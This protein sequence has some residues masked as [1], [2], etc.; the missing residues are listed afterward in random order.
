MFEANKATF[1]FLREYKLVSIIMIIALSL[2]FATSVFFHGMS[3]RNEVEIDKY[4]PYAE[5]T[6]IISFEAA[7]KPSIDSI[8]KSMD[9]L[10]TDIHDLVVRGN[11]CLI[12][13][14]GARQDID[15]S[16]YFR[17][18]NTPVSIIRGT[19][20]MKD[21]E[22]LINAWNF[23]DVFG[24][25]GSAIYD[26]SDTNRLIFRKGGDRRIA[27][28]VYYPTHINLWGIIVKYD[29]FYGLAEECTSIE[30]AFET[31]L[32]NEEEKTFV[33]S[34][35]SNVAVTSFQYPSKIMQSSISEGNIQLS[36]YRFIVLVCVFF[37]M[38]LLTYLYYLRK[39]EFTIIRMVGGQNKDLIALILSALFQIVFAA[40]LLGMVIVGVL[41]RF[42]QFIYIFQYMS[43]S[44]VIN[45]IAFFWFMT[46]LIGILQLVFAK[47]VSIDSASE[48]A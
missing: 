30:V 12:N 28:V 34:V 38:K 48:G 41:Y 25:E 17:V 20:E 19:N 26:M 45:D 47:H 35:N 33:H 40:T 7:D 6:Y 5:G 39:S 32:S 46:L 23:S 29:Q 18:I 14:N 16:G 3:R 10:D 27:G 2:L 42:L 21:G 37:A 31:Q 1:K 4:Q 44:Q 36:M 15:I 13:H 24:P 8:L 9:G 11:T 43:I 22:V